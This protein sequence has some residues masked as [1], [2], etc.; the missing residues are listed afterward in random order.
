MILPLLLRKQAIGPLRINDAVGDTAHGKLR[1][2]PGRVTGPS[3]FKRI[4]TRN[5]QATANLDQPN[6]GQFTDL[7]TDVTECKK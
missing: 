5:V 1:W 3:E 6:C 4:E 7:A 2:R